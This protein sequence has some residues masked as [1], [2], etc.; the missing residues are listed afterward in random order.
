MWRR[1]HLPRR[2]CWNKQ[3]ILYY[4]QFTLITHLYDGPASKPS[5]LT[6]SLAMVTNSVGEAH[7]LLPRFTNLATLTVSDESEV[8]TG[9][10]IWSLTPRAVNPRAATVQQHRTTMLYDR[11]YVS[12]K[13]MLSVSRDCLCTSLVTATGENRPNDVY[14]E[15]IQPA[16]ALYG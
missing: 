15:R 8:C 5:R 13:I 9:R 14:Q 1:R 7:A 11:K 16:C 12:D 3:K 2:R 4:L 6:N 10:W